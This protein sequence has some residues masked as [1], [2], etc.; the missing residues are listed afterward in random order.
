[1]RTRTVASDIG[2]AYGSRFNSALRGMQRVV[3]SGPVPSFSV[4]FAGA[5]KLSLAFNFSRTSNATQFDSLGRLVW[6]PANFVR[7]TVFA[8]VVPQT[9]AATGGV[10]LGQFSWLTP[11]AATAL[12]RE[13]VAKGTLPDGTPYIDI[14]ISGTNN[15]AGTIFPHL[16]FLT[17]SVSAG[18]FQAGQQVGYSQ[19]IQVIAGNNTGMSSSGRAMFQYLNGTGYIGQANTYPAGIDPDSELKRISVFGTTI[20]TTDRTNAG[21]ELSVMAGATVNIT[22]RIAAP[23]CEYWSANSP[24]AYNANTST[25]SPFYG[26]RFDYNPATLSSLGLLIEELRTNFLGTSR[27]LTSWSN[28]DVTAAFTDTGVQGLPN[29][30]LSVV[31][32]SAGTAI[33]IPWVN[34]TV[35]AGSTITGSVYLKY[36]GTPWIRI[37]T[38]GPGF[39]DGAEAFFNIQTGVKGGVNVRG[40]GTAFTNSIVNAGN[41]WYRCTV[42]V[43]PNG[44]YTVP[45]FAVLSAT[46]DGNSTRVSGATYSLCEPQLEVGGFSTSVIPTFGA[47]ATRNVESC[48][49]PISGQIANGVGTLNVNYICRAVTVGLFQNIVAL[50]QSSSDRITLYE[51][52]T[53]ASGEVRAANVASASVTAPGAFVQRRAALGYETN[54]ANYAINGVLGTLST[55]AAPPTGITNLVIGGILPGTSNGQTWTQKVVY[56]PTRLPDAQLQA[57]TA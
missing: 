17:S 16:V 28:V 57:L 52:G 49:V 7:D 3:P 14:R 55:T 29:T 53:S 41:G 19:L 32:G 25:T 39:T 8:N 12:V 47:A 40:I 9:L 44:V 2:G 27:S 22:L 45:S 21:V 50:S 23:Q 54:S 51:F 13:I 11:G 30:A 24:Q 4:Q 5:N 38:T 48:Y 20:A 37:I 18:L 42:S 46:A 33:I 1:M 56:Y 36:V 35:T 15:S 34:G 43:I 26:P 6:A 31:E 10:T